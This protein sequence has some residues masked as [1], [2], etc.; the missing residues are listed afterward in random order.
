MQKSFTLNNFG[1]SPSASNPGVGVS[2]VVLLLSHQTEKQKKHKT[3]QNKK[4]TTKCPKFK[5]NIVS[6]SF[7]ACS[8]SS[9]VV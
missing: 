1:V 2:E 5:C 4:N 3:T 6:V 7:S 9:V 8:C